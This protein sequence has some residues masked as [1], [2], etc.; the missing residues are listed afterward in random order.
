MPGLVVLH[1]LGLRL[2]VPPLLCSYHFGCWYFGWQGFGCD[3][4]NQGFGAALVTGAPGGMLRLRGRQ[5]RMLQALGFRPQILGLVMLCALGLRLLVPLL[6]VHHVLDLR[7]RVLRP[8]V[9]QPRMLQ[10]MELRPQVLGL[11][12]LYV[13]R[14]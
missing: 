8:L 7:P 9:R 3:F 10:A 6:L 2:L 4:A 12:A 1:G 13:R 14:R 5:P 11:V